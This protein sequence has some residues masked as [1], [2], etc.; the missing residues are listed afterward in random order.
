MKKTFFIVLIWA[1]PA[2]CYAGA[3]S[4]KEGQLSTELV[5]N[6]YS[7]KEDF[8]ASG[9]LK[10]KP[11]NGKYSEERMELK[12]DYGYSDSTDILFYVPIKWSEYED[13]NISLHN[14]GVVD[15][16]L[17]FKRV[18]WY[19]D[20]K[21]SSYVASLLAMAK[22]SVYDEDDQLAL[23]T[24][25]DNY[26]V[27]FL[28]GHSFIEDLIGDTVIHRAFY[29]AELGFRYRT[30]G[31]ADQITYFA[32]GGYL[33]GHGVSVKTEIDGVEAVGDEDRKED[34]T[35][36][37][38]SLTYGTN[39]NIALTDRDQGGMSIS[40]SYGQALLGNNTSEGKEGV[41]KLMYLF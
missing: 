14:S 40:I 16:G 32:E 7:A 26:E 2:I 35:I 21:Q 6:Y 23:G 38:L 4:L 3:W 37:R 10:Q 17:G 13:D 28:L 34:Y 39:N 29:G 41:L 9:N 36:A 25:E 31:I 18:L 11:N 15:I 33:I 12:F 20:K 22:F 8:D 1:F 30:E 24:G 19:S 27:K 5:T